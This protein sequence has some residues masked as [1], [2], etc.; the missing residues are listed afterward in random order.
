MTSIRYSQLILCVRPAWASSSK[1]IRCQYMASH[2][3]AR[4]SESQLASLCS[5]QYIAAARVPFDC[6][7]ESSNLRLTATRWNPII[8]IV[9]SIIGVW[10][11]F[12]ILLNSM[13]F[14]NLCRSEWERIMSETISRRL[15]NIKYRRYEFIRFI[16]WVWNRSENIW[17]QKRPDSNTMEQT[18]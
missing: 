5:F 1:L 18:A 9:Q 14:F 16:A 15:I 17:T 4:C 3:P 10:Y 8:F 13:G 7:A 12:S 11:Q 6:A 2:C